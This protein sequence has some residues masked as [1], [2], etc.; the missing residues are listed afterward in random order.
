MKLSKRS[1]SA[2]SI[3]GVILYWLY[4]F[5]R[6]SGTRPDFPSG[7]E[8]LF[9]SIIKSKI[10]IIAAVYLLLRLE[11]EG[12][13][14]IGFNGERFFR[15][16]TTGI[17]F[18]L[19]SWVLV[20]VIVIPILNSVNPGI[21]KD[22]LDMAV[23]MKDIRTVYLWIPIVIFGAFAEELLR[24]FMLTRFENSFGKTGLYIALIFTSVTFGIGHLYQGPNAAIGTGLGG[25]MYA[26]VY[27]RKR[28]AVE[29]FTSHAFFNIIS[30]AGGFLMNNN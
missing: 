13:R 30:V 24:I 3:A 20:N 9:L 5:Y 8:E 25:L 6:S 14:Q 26:L 12:F 11:G 10:I 17:L 28:S 2:V 4:T 18:G 23:Y 19:A 27:L 16:L 22:G 7:T 15:H 21:S 1:A 29:A